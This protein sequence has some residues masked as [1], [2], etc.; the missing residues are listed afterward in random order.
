MLAWAFS[1]FLYFGCME[2]LLRGQTIGKRLMGL[3]VIRVDGFSLD[4]TSILVRNVFRVLDQLPPVWLAPVISKRSQRFGDMAAGTTVIVD[5]PEQLSPIR[6]FLED[7]P[8]ADRKFTFDGTM[9]KR[10][11]ESDFV[12]I[13][14]ILNRWEALPKSQQESLLI[15]I[16]PPLTERLKTTPPPVE[17]RFDFLIDL[18]GAEYRRQ[19]RSL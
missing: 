10:V 4:A 12:A 14:K 17:Q 1:S 16:I 13:E 2:L 7:M 15:Q 9:L 11:R 6:Q 3:R 8:A 19:H 5:R 18:L